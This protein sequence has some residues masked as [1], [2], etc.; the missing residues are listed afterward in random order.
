[1]TSVKNSLGASDVAPDA[2]LMSLGLDS[3]GAVELRNSLEAA[4]GVSLPN[5]LVFD[6]PTV[7]A[8]A[9]LLLE[10]LSRASGAAGAPLPCR[11][12]PGRER[13][14]GPASKRRPTRVPSGTADD[15][16]V[17]RRVLEVSRAVT[18]L[19]D[20][21]SDAP[22]MTSG[23]DSL[24]AVELR[25]SLEAEMGVPL[26]STLVFDHP[27]PDAISELLR[28]ILAA[29]DL[30]LE[31]A[32]SSE[33]EEEGDE[34]FTPSTA[35]GHRLILQPG[36][37]GSVSATAT[38]T[39]GILSS[40]FRLPSS[41][42]G[43]S[44]PTASDGWGT[45]LRSS[46][47]DAVSRVPLQRWDADGA[48]AASFNPAGGGSAKATGTAVLPVQLG[49]FLEAV[50]QF[51]AA[52]FGLSPHEAALMVSGKPLILPVSS[53]AALLVRGAGQPPKP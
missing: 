23:L 14:R 49:S 38:T 3:L 1:M 41:L 29:R 5:T 46:A 31:E 8:I 43:G 13:R 6:Y 27:T 11:P 25:N 36:R 19:P 10:R 34:E 20:L 51:D 9:E 4:L 2:P 42:C 22:L 33:G 32:F 17:L 21:A 52:V 53:V 37:Q 18:G 30:A 47:C 28:G 39:V 26:P 12:S 45:Y 35:P 50:E 24:G 7:D 40:A 48:E 15:A 16:S 44:Q